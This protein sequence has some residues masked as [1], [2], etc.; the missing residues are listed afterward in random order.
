MSW[1]QNVGASISSAL[2]SPRGPQAQSAT[3]APGSEV[4]AEV[5]D[6]FTMEIVKRAQD[7]AKEAAQRAAS[8]DAETDDIIAMAKAFKEL[9]AKTEGIKAITKAKVFKEL[10]A[11]T[12]GIEAITKAKAFK[13]KETQQEPHE[14]AQLRR[15]YSER[16]TGVDDDSEVHSV[17]SE[18]G[19]ESLTSQALYE[20]FRDIICD[21]KVYPDYDV[22]EELA[23]LFYEVLS[24]TPNELVKPVS[25][26]KTLFWYLSACEIEG[27]H[28][29]QPMLS[30]F[31]TVK[32]DQIRDNSGI[33]NLWLLAFAATKG[34]PQALVAFCEKFKSEI[35]KDDLTQHIDYG[36]FS[37][38]A[39]NLMLDFCNKNENSSDP[40]QKK[41]AMELIKWLEKKQDQEVNR[42]RL[43]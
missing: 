28:F 15:T 37:G 17:R 19:D 3:A 9:E 20:R 40:T 29:I 14:I 8:T 31:S 7:A 43:T 21:A 4:T 13:Q 22:D 5:K 18:E 16:R 24:L 36:S 32:F 25:R 11:Q 10:E 12:E 1:L 41:Y 42:K 33:P 35:T 27:H 34:H 26:N 6:K 23:G 2:F 30:Q 39:L 38:S